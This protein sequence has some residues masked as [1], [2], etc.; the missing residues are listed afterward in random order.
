VTATQ[1][2]P[3]LAPAAGT[4]DAVSPSVSDRSGGER[5]AAV[6]A[7]V[8]L[9]VCGLHG[10]AGASTLA[11]LIAE[12]IGGAH[13][14]PVL[15]C[16]APGATGDQAALAGTTSRVSLAQLATAVA[17]GRVPR[18]FWGRHGSLRLLATAPQ[19]PPAVSTVALIDVLQ[20][21]RGEHAVTVIDVGTLRDPYATAIVS[22]AS[23]V[24]WT[25]RLGPGAVARAQQLL[26]SPL[27]PVLAGAQAIAARTARPRD[28]FGGQ[29]GALRRLADA[30][31]ARLILVPELPGREDRP[32]PASTPARR[33][34]SAAGRFLETR[35]RA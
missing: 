29:A 21:A 32:D 19:P 4:C 24:L 16:E 26:A 10:G 3:Q 2:L 18:S 15:L 11:A 35:W 25:L 34:T 5:P 12:T 28:R 20:A 1:S 31:H 8:L 14:D 30:H 17:A 33:L 6:P 27:A 13:A 9:A 22:A 23:H 7:G